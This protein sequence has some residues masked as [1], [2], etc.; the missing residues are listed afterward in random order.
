LMN[1]FYQATPR[2]VSVL[3]KF[4]LFLASFEV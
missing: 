4:H 1:P 2:L 3:P